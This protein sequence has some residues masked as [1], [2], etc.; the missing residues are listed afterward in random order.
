MLDIEA[1]EDELDKVSTLNHFLMEEFL[2]NITTSFNEKVLVLT[3]VIFL[4]RR[5]EARKEVS[6]DACSFTKS[7]WV[8]SF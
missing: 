4:Y 2:G 8:L 6:D 5:L 3:S 7:L 1:K